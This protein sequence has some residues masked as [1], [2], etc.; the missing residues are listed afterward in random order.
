MRIASIGKS[1]LRESS[2]QTPTPETSTR[3]DEPQLPAHLILGANDFAK[4][5]TW[6]RL[7]VGHR[8]DPV[9]KFMRFGWALMSPGAETDLSSMYLSVNSTAD[10]EGLC[11]LD[12]LGLVDTP[13]GD[14][15]DVYNELR[16]SY[17]VLPK[18]GMKPHCPGKEIIHL[19][20]ATMK[21]VFTA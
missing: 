16:N 14:Q 8:G 20:L 11:A 9:A 4:I 2:C 18:D 1:P 19:S 17:R 15:R 7:R 21:E 13:M 3:V 6:E 12:F 10:Y 5:R